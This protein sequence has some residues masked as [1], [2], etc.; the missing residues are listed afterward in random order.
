MISHPAYDA[1]RWQLVENRLD[2]GV[3]P[4]SESLFALGNGHLGWRGTLDEGEPHGIPGSYLG[5]V[6]EELPLPVRESGYGDPEC[7]ETLVNVVNGKLLRLFVDDEPFDVRLGT[8]H[9]HRRWL[10]L[11]R[12]LLHRSTDWTS[13][14]G[15]R[16]V[17][18]STRLVS[19]T[20]RALAAV[21]YEV[22]AV[23]RETQVAVQSELVANEP[24][25]APD[26][27]DPRAPQH[28]DRPLEPVEH[29]A[30]GGRLRLLHRTRR[31]GLL[32]AAAAGHRVSGPKGCSVHGGAEEDVARCTV[33]ARLGSGRR[34]RIV[35][36]VAY[37]WSGMRSAASLRDEAEAALAAGQHTGWQGL[38]E[39]QR[40]YLDAFWAR[41]DVELEGDEEIQHAVRFGLFH[42][43]QAAARAEEQPIGAK[44]LT[45]PGY[46]GHCF[47]DTEAFV[48]PVLT[49]TAPEAA[50]A[51]L[52]WRHRTLDRAL[53]RAKQLQLRGAA[54]PWRTISGRECSA[55]WPAGTAAFHVNA[56]VADAAVR[57]AQVTGDAGFERA[58]GV[59]LLTHV[60]RLWMALGH[61]GRDGAFHIDGVTG[62]DEYSAVA[63][64]NTY[65]NLM[66]Q[67]NLRAAALAVRR[68]PAEAAALGADEAE[69]RAWLTAADRMA[70]PYNAEL[71]V[72]EQSAGFTRHAPWDFAATGPDGYPLMLH[73]PYFDL[74]RS[75]VVKQAD[76]V[77]A[78]FLRDSA[79]TPQQK[80]RDFA[81]YEPITV[82]DSSLSACVQSVVA[83]D[84]GHLDLAFDYLG[85]SAEMDLEDLQHNTRDGLHLAA[86]A[87]VWLALV[88]GFGGLRRHGGHLAFAPRL[89]ASLT[90]L[91]YHV[92]AFQRRL[93]IE[94]TPREA[95]YTLLSGPRLEIRHYGHPLTL[96]RGVPRVRAI[97][98]LRPR[99]P[100]AQPPGRAPRRKEP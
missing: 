83:A 68:Y 67:A 82:R 34:L 44:G 61:H 26:P 94:A 16:V 76:L 73:H 23:H 37:A 87:G 39:E 12:G 9:H 21:A 89:P 71:G 88:A 1:G 7:A 90:R 14:A 11:R 10:D 15:S 96:E 4:Q 38:A 86:L 27:H 17:V 78:L 70:V 3:L 62:P 49:Y 40:R 72:H 74:Y 47:W 95:T 33:V 48:L 54:F 97:P 75:Q 79:F 64:D 13:P 85:E 8:L 43:L 32:V 53:E 99:H 98:P 28:L 57:Y 91:A 65:T 51:S 30:D 93:R 18:R 80:A 56:A 84:V 92:T 25:P 63:D 66:A 22:E 46:G 81:Y 19:L 52:R 58:A 24:L 5:G 20:Q 77:L 100:P 6:H 2:L 50:A 35:K 60:A 36:T 41:A 55:Y 69:R 29:A 42:L 31:S 59:E 45:G